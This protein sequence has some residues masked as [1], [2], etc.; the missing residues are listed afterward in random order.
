MVKPLIDERTHS[1]H[2]KVP[3]A[4]PRV[5]C[6]GRALVQVLVNLLSNAAKYTDRG[7][8]I[9]LGIASNGGT[10]SFDVHDTGVGITPEDQA[11]LFTY[12]TQVG[13]KHRH[14]MTG[15]GVGLALTRCLVERMG[16]QIA[17]V[18]AQGRGSSFKVSRPL[19][20]T[21]SH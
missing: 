8:Q 20:P 13:A 16:G 18:S 6:D 9:T 15:S 11:E 17:V 7:G 21:S 5:L 1:L 19:D 3:E 12:F 2:I 14:H 10:A 4:M